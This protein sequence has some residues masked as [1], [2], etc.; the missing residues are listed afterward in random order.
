MVAEEKENLRLLLNNKLND[1]RYTKQQQWHLLYLTLIAIGGITSLAIGIKPVLCYFGLFLIGF[2][3]I[4]GVLGGGFIIY[5]AHWLHNYRNEKS[6]YLEQLGIQPDRQ[7][8]GDNVI[9]T[10]SFC[11]IIILTLVA[12]VW[13]IKIKLS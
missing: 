9:F 8:I 11:V 5:Y 12:S 10:V 4:V 6:Y 7:K 2:D 13:A 1:I 3:I